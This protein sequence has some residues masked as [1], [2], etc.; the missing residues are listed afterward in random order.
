M[1]SSQ[2]K[3]QKFSKLQQWLT[4]GK[5]RHRACIDWI[6]SLEQNLALMKTGQ[7]STNTGKAVYSGQEKII[8]DNGRRLGTGEI[9]KIEIKKYDV[10]LDLTIDTLQFRIYPDRRSK[11]LISD[12]V[13]LTNVGPHRIKLLAY[14]LEHPGRY[15]SMENAAICHDTPDEKREPATL[16]KTISLLRQALGIP[17]LNNPYIKT[18]QSTLP[19]SYTM[20]TKW[21]YL[22]IK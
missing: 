18:K 17:G 12:L 1:D 2:Y 11:L 10:I 3:D 4:E 13:D 14:M 15:I 16:R 22:L 21:S 7:T 8:F 19:C 20:D 6:E 9:A 5:E